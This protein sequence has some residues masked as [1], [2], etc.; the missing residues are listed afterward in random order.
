VVCEGLIATLR[1]ALTDC[2]ICL[3]RGGARSAYRALSDHDFR[4]TQAGV[5]ECIQLG[6]DGPGRVPGGG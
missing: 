2:N 1:T 5:R 4:T 6:W 3:T